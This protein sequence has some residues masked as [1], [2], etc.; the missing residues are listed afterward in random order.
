MRKLD[1]HKKVDAR[2]PVHH[3]TALKRRYK[4][5]AEGIRA[6]VAAHVKEDQ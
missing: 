1:D 4:T 3:L 2:I 5:L 6:A